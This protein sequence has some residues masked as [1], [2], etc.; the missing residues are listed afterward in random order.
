LFYSICEENGVGAVIS[1][2]S[3]HFWAAQDK[4]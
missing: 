4:K 1:K 2:D 3:D